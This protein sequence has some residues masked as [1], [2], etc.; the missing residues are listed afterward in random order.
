MVK[1]QTSGSHRYVNI[2]GLPPTSQAACFLASNLSIQ[3]KRIAFFDAA[4]DLKILQRLRKP[5]AQF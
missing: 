3:L 5:P 4:G 2:G 1:L